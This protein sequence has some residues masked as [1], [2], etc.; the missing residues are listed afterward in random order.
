M[1]RTTVFHAMVL[2]LL[3]LAGLNSCTLLK[4][5]S[6]DKPLSVSDL[7]TRFKVQSFARE[8]LYQHEQAADSVALLAK[9]DKRVELNSL[10]W[11]LMLVS[12]LGKLA[13][14][15]IPRVSL[16]DTWAYMLVLQQFLK[17]ESDTAFFGNYQS[18]MQHTA[19]HHVAHIE[20]IA[21]G[22]LSA[23]DFPRYKAFVENYAAE[24]QLSAENDLYYEPIS[25]AYLAFKQLPDS[26]AVQTVGTLSQVMDEASNK[27][28]FSS[29]VLSK[30]LGWQAELLLRAQGFDSIPVETR[31]NL[32][33]HEL[34]RLASV[35]ESSPEMLS[36]AIRQFRETVQP[37]F[38][39]LHTGLETAL[40]RL[41]DNQA[42]LDT[43]VL[44]E[45]VALDSIIRRERQALTKEAKEIADTGLKNALDGFHKM[46][47]TI[48]FFAVLALVVVLGLPFYLG[49]IT[50]KRAAKQK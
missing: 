44:R 47:R 40:Q 15:P 32:L 7:N 14:Q 34:N 48:L 41:S 28:S 26:A 50:G 22:L 1:K 27:L 33:Q 18:I 13:F 24:H 5:E 45:R 9:G 39:S 20:Q 3:L 11:K 38:T 6:A 4:I 23:K 36:D 8:V 49:Y 42:A 31:L 10:R 2:A 35:A 30:K 12:Q 43:L 19:D 25:Q 29:D 37:L 16:T 17:A 46:L 21:A